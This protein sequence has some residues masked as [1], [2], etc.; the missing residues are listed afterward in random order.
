MITVLVDTIKKNFL[1]R[2]NDKVIELAQLLSLEKILYSIGFS[3]SCDK[4]IGTSLLI[5]GYL[6]KLSKKR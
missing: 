2:K 1:R 3:Y 4:L 5:N 6:R